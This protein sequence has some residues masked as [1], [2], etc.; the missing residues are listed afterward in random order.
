MDQ[1]AV[2]KVLPLLPLLAAVGETGQVTLAAATLAVPQPS[3]SRGLAR[4][5]TVLGAPLIERRGRGITLTPAGEALLP[6]ARAALDAVAA[7]LEAVRE[8]DA[9]AF[10]TL[11]I[12]F[13]NTLGD[14]VVP[15]LIKAFL[16]EHP[17]TRFELRQ[18]SHGQCLEALDAGAA[19]IA[20][21]SPIE[22]RSD[23]TGVPLHSEPLVLLV[24]PGHRLARSAR[25]DLAEAS[26]E[27]FIG[28]KP[29]F[30]LRSML[31][32]LAAASGFTPTIAFEGDDLHTVRGLVAAGLGVALVP[33]D[34]A[35]T[36]AV[37]IPIAGAAARRRIGAVWHTGEPSSLGAAMQRLLRRRGP[38]LAAAAL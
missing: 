19:E 12:A 32:D 13:Q 35:G 15:A 2:R 28:L 31:A 23:L 29:G 3:V 18:G 16:V 24:P 5:G 27:T 37:E 14:R 6:H 25:I 38:A 30:G 34:R 4:L 9:Q 36:D 33:R 10:G 20:L 1:E 7:G 11:S 8:Q 26:G 17:R 21:I 22:E